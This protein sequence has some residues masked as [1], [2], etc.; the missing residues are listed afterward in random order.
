MKIEAATII[1]PLS[2][3]NIEVPDNATTEQKQEAV[4]QEVV[5]AYPELENRI[6]ADGIIHDSTDDDIIE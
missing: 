4:Y 2:V 6:R 5:R 3:S 1:I